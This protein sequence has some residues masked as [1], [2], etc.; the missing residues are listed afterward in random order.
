MTIFAPIDEAFDHLSEEVEKN[1]TSSSALL[2]QLIM[3]HVV[4]N[5]KIMISDLEEEDML[6][7]S[8]VGDSLRINTYLK[9]K[10]Y[11]V[12]CVFEFDRVYISFSSSLVNSLGFW[13]EFFRF[14]YC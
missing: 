4:P 13:F 14:Q 8:V 3:Y 9:S 11:Q 12:W 7:K 5:K 6:V 2:E 1:L 10:F